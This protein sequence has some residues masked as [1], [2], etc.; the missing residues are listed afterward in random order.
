M[1]RK[2]LIWLNNNQEKGA[3]N[4]KTDYIVFSFFLLLSFIFW[5]LNNLGKETE[6]E[7]RYP[8][9]FVNFP[10]ERVLSGDLPSKLNLFL[11][12]PGYSILKLKLSGN[13]APVILDFSEINYRRI[14]GD[15][16][17][18][19]Y[20][21][22]ST[23]IPNLKNELRSECQIISIR[24]DTLFFS[25]DRMVSRLVP[26]ISGLEVVTSRQYFIKGNIVFD[27][28]S[29]RISGPSRLLDTIKFIRTKYKKLTG[30]NQTIKRN[31]SLNIPDNITSSVRKVMMTIPSEQFTEAEILVPV[32]IMNLPD[33]IDVK[34]FPDVVTVKGLVAVN[35]YKK[36]Q[37]IPFEVI[38]DL[39]KTNLK[40]PERI[41]L[42]IRN[43]PLFI[44]SLRI[45][46]PDVDFL[47]EKKYK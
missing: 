24:P 29:V 21:S 46:P 18:G 20:V 37:D 8:V 35:D 25:F 13:R 6:T 32:K 19:Y 44:T 33:S 7:I 11:K 40:T 42:E 36:F 41:P 45:I 17:H 39:D 5:Y 15:R 28:D 27:P 23:L 47:I 38:L 1:K 30:V 12:G 4:R 16:N 9:R 3:R 14:P 2:P 31:I 10:K 22:T 43:V 26:V 34:I